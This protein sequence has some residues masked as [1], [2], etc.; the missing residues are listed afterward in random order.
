MDDSP[1]TAHK[2]PLSETGHG[3]LPHMSGQER[4]EVFLDLYKQLEE[5]GRS[6]LRLREE[7]HESVIVRLEQRG[8]LRGYHA[9]L[10]SCRETRNLLQH[11]QKID[12]QYAVEPSDALVAELRKLIGI[13][14]ARPRCLDIGVKRQA[15]FTCTEHDP[16]TR[17]IMAIRTKGYSCVPVMRGKCVVG[18]FNARSLLNGIADAQGRLDANLK[19]SQITAYTSLDNRGAESFVFISRGTYVDE[20]EAQFEREFSRGRRIA[21]A[22]VTEHGK[23][24]EGL[25]GMLTAWDVLGN[26]D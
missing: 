13:L 24:D 22:F 26:G 6:A 12:G 16:V 8:P 19:F 10:E 2:L 14:R 11:T 9:E 23:R 7:D 18:A 17:A 1:K 15:I 21:A 25:L 5:T 4:A 20:L 3:D